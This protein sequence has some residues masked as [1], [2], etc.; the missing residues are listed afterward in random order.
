[1]T[2]VLLLPGFGGRATQPLLVKLERRLVERGYACQRLAPPRGRPTPGLEREVAWLSAQLD[3]AAGPVAVVGR[4]FGGRLGVRVTDRLAALVLLGFPV[5]PPGKRRPLDEAALA[6][7][8]C[9][10]LV[11]QGTKDPLGPLRVVQGLAAKNTR[12]EVLPVRGAAHGFGRHEATALD[13]AAAW[14]DR[15]LGG[16]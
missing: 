2:R 5:R 8:R 11:V 1:M 6:S 4:S 10:T 9:P 7:A 3:G 15:T 16:R 14:L 12:V 13:D